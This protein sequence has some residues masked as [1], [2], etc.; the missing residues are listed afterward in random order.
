LQQAERANTAS[1]QIVT[2]ERPPQ[3]PRP[4]LAS[5]SVDSDDHRGHDE[6]RVRIIRRDRDDDQ[7]DQDAD[8]S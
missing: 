8:I 2:Q 5:S 1:V 7:R 6:K 4:L 3:V